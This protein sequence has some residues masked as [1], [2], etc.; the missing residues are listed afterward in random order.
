MRWV[1]LL[2]LAFAPAMADQMVAAH[3]A[4]RARLHLP[5]LV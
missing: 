2:G 1:M 5:P 4:V 3:N